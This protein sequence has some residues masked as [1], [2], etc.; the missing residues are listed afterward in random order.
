[1]YADRP[2]HDEMDTVDTAHGEAK[3]PHVH[4]GVLD[5]ISSNTI[6][7]KICVLP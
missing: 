3:T 6:R 5:Y 2:V 4:D 7:M 1:M